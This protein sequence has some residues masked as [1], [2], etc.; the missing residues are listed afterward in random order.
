M[1]RR[2]TALAAAAALAT[3]MVGASAGTALASTTT[4]HDLRYGPRFG[5]DS[6]LTLAHAPA[7]LRAAVHKTLGTARPADSA[8]QKDKLTA[9]NGAEDD[10]LGYSVAIS[11]TTAVVGAPTKNT[12]TGAAY[13]FVKSGQTW[14]QQ[15]ELTA[16]DGAELNYFGDSVAISGSTAV[17]GAYGKNSNTGAVYVFNRSATGTW[18]Q[19]TELTASDGADNDYFGW[20]VAIAKSTVVAGAIGNDNSTGAAYVFGRSGST[21]SQ[22]AELTANDGAAGDRFGDSVAISGSTA[23]VGA[24]YHNTYAGAAYV[25]THSGKKWSQQTELTAADSATNDYFGYS[26]AIA[27]STVVVG[28]PH[29]NGY[30]GAAYVFTRSGSTWTYQA[31]IFVTD[32]L[33]GGLF[34]ASVAMAGSTL[35]VGR[36]GTSGNLG[37]AFVYTRS[38]GV[39]SQQAELTASDGVTGD[40]FGWSVAVSGSTVVVGAIARDT[41][42]GAAYVFTGSGGTWSQAAELIPADGQQYGYFGAAVAVSGSTAVVPSYGVNDRTGATYMY[43]NV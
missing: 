15:T 33:A 41:G 3:A 21:W 20:S 39:W 38:G 26:V 35:V 37:A 43:G 34:G 31:E 25:F 9:S 5:P 23:V 32:G 29:K 11:G 24:Y 40:A 22:Q 6:R 7:G 27:G 12:A 2:M 13:V 17:V 30:T 28:A 1:K 16:N 19:K 18:S 14:K 42:T 36:P 8:F 4:H 10:N